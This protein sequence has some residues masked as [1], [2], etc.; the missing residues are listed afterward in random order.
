MNLLRL[1]LLAFAFVLLPVGM[2]GADRPN[3][4]LVISD[5]QGI[6]DLGLHGNDKIKTPN[7][8][9][10]GREG[11]RLTRFYV[12]PVC[13]PTRAAL[14]TGRYQYRTGVIHTSRG[15]AKMHGEE[16]TVAE[17]LGKG[18][19]RTGLFGKWHL[20]DNYPMRPQDQG[21]QEVLMHKSGGITQPPDQ[22]NSYFDPFLWHNGKRIQ[23]KG[24]CTDVFFN[25]AMEFATAN[26][27]KPFFAYIP[28]NAPHTPLEVSEDYV[29]PYRALGL[30]DTT[31]KVYGMV[32]NLDE[33]FGRLLIHLEK[34][35]IRENT[36]VIFMTDNG[37]QQARY[38]MNL[39]GRKSMTYE[40]G[41][42]VPF[43]VQ[44]PAKWKGA[45]TVDRIAA[46]MDVLPTLLSV[47]GIKTPAD[48]KMDGMNL[49]ALLSGTK[50]VE[51]VDRNLFFQVH[52]GLTPHAYQNMAVIN[53]R[54]KLVG[55]PGSFN[56][57][58]DVV[59]AKGPV[60]EL[61]DLS[62]DPAEERNLASSHPE[63]LQ[64]LRE[65]YERWFAEVKGTRGFKPGD[66]HI[67]NAAENPVHLCY[68]QDGSWAGKEAK[69]WQVVVEQAG[70]YRVRSVREAIPAGTLMVVVWQGKT[71]RQE[72]KEG[73]AVFELVKGA[74]QLEVWLEDQAGQ[75]LAIDAG[76]IQ[77]DVMVE[78]L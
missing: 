9:K 17:L 7:L 66:I 28:L 14:M 67:G 68:Y 73:R 58:E 43:F 32:Q 18:G 57:E 41:I 29:K 77:G 23:A 16:T 56:K 38:T 60:L 75:K 39:R 13:A 6:G 27:R 4:I 37:P 78:R 24:Y 45:R 61:Y 74:G 34:L 51:L 21:F 71:V 76:G 2:H 54:W 50:A 1:C 65:A 72:L 44:W 70:K 11:I 30:D 59:T 36:L 69:G 47:C 52:R 35:K 48:L 42:R 62:A 49:E 31:A 46:D 40:G 22:P 10:F 63:Q 15:G 64:K 53:Q 26:Q 5:D 20:G 19:Y 33:N 3:V 55:S 12:S 8:D 25:A